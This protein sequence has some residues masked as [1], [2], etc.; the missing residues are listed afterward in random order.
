MSDPYQNP[1]ESPQIGEA[2]R[3]LIS[4]ESPTS[5]AQLEARIENL[6]RQLAENW[7]LGSWLKRAFAVLGYFIVAYLMIA[8]G[9][10]GIFTLVG[11]VL[12]AMKG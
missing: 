8:L 6:E 1:Y 11:L 3:S 7:F 10:Y 4:A 5:I 12:I 9:F 2:R